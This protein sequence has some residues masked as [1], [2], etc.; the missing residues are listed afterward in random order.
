LAGTRTATATPDVSETGGPTITGLPFTNGDICNLTTTYTDV[1]IDICGDSYKVLR[2]WLIIDWCTGAQANYDQL[3][4]VL[5][6]TG[7]TA[8]C[9]TAPLTINVYSASAPSGGGPHQIC[10]GN[11]VIPPLQVTGD[12]C[13]GL[14]P[15]GYKTQLWTLGAG[16]LLQTINGNGGTF[17]NV[18]R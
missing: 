13:S 14:N 5:D 6:Q 18:D 9:P 12:D 10:K 17:P 11:V 3:I 16:T 8:V 4:K 15:A 2:K 7:P 1:K